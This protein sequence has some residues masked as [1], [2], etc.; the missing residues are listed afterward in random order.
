[1]SSIMP[2]P[3]FSHVVARVL[4]VRRLLKGFPPAGPGRRAKGPISVRTQTR[5]CERGESFVGLQMWLYG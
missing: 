2:L 3:T 1:M 5:E 4:P